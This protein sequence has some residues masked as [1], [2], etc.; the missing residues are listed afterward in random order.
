VR[1]GADDDQLGPLLL[2]DPAE[3][4]GRIADRDP[5]VGLR[6]ALLGQHPIDE[7]HATRPGLAPGGGRE[8]RILD[9]VYRE[10]A[11]VQAPRE[12]GGGAQRLLRPRGLVDRA[13]DRLGA[14][15]VLLPVSWRTVVA[16]GAAGHPVGSASAG[17]R[18]P[19]WGRDLIARSPAD[20]KTGG[21]PRSRGGVMGGT[22]VCG[23]T[24]TAGSRAAA[25]LAAAL[26]ARL[27]L[28]LVLVHVSED[29][30]AAAV[31]AEEARVIQGRPAQALAEVAD[32]EGA[33]LI[34]LGSSA[35][36]L[37]RRLLRS[38]LARELDA[39]TDVPILVAPPSTRAR[40]GRRLALAAGPGGR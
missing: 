36:G 21:D 39:A 10:E 9:H 25:E 11:H 23:V 28:R 29:D 1:L 16:P 8:R 40:S 34:V 26:A 35:A 38:G 7:A 30:A 37:G 32:E 17:G 20:R 4:L 19:N 27:G 6:D 24:D 33:D 22:I 13:H 15:G 2:R 3:V 31:T 14:H 12:P 18:R 5:A